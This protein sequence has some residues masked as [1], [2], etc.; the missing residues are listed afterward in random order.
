MSPSIWRLV[1]E[2]DPLYKRWNGETVLYDRFSGDTHVLDD[3][4]IVVIESLSQKS[5]SEA[6]LLS[7]VAQCFG[8]ESGVDLGGMLQQRLDALVKLNILQCLK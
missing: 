2:F 3:F 4:C 5:L 6:R 7:E 8:V 1:P